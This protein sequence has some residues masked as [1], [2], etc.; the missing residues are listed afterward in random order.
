[1]SAGIDF[2]L[3]RGDGASPE[4]FTTVGGFTTN[5]LNQSRALIEKTNKSSNTNR[6]LLSGVGTKSRTTSGSGVI[7]DKTALEA[8]QG[9]YESG[10]AVNYQIVVPGLG[11]YEGPFI[12]QQFN[13]TGG[14][15]DNATFD[16]T[17]EAA[18]DVTFTV[19]S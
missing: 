17:L 12:V 3:K 13:F 18:D 5:S 8:I 4:V 15:D 16:I 1:M 9:D 14:H 2:L 7:Q 10:A 11:T 6:Q 19:E